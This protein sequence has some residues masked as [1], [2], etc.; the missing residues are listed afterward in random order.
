MPRLTSG[1]FLRTQSGHQHA[2]NKSKHNGQPAGTTTNNTANDYTNP[3]P[4]TRLG[5]RCANLPT[6]CL[7]RIGVGVGVLPAVNIAGIT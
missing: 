6:S 5:E 7:N 4:T 2:N 3:T 1:V